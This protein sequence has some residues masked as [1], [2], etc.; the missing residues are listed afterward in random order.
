MCDDPT[1][2]PAD[3]GRAA[4]L[5]AAAV[6]VPP[7]PLHPFHDSSGADGQPEI[8]LESPD[9]AD[10]VVDG[11]AVVG[12]APPPG[13]GHVPIPAELPWLDA[14]SSLVPLNDGQAVG[15]L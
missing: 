7:E 9:A 12:P 15:V 5:E 6:G 10:G 8:A 3:C 14:T 2:L 4:V 1:T 11:H 13:S